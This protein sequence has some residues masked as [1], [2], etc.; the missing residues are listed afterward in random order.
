MPNITHKISTPAAAEDFFA[1]VSTLKGLRSW[2]TTDVSGDPEQG[3]V[4][5]FR[6]GG[7]GP[8]MKVETREA[9]RVVWRCI[10]GPDEWLNTTF[11]FRFVAEDKGLTALYFSHAGWQAETPFHFHCSMKWA[12]FLLSLKE[13][14]ELGSGRPFPDDI[15]IE[16]ATTR[17]AA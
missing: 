7:G 5:A 13:Y 9:D 11:E 17:R 4:L 14:V 12:S 10:A 16:G 6:F 2:W 15:Q 1:A 8:D 3:G